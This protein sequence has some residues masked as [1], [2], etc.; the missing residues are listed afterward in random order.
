MYDLV[1]V[2]GGFAGL[3]AGVRAKELGLHAAI[4]EAGAEDEN[5]CN[6]RYSGGHLSIGMDD[7]SKDP[8][9][10]A[11]RINELT[12]HSFDAAFVAQ[13]AA[14]A[15]AMVDWL[16]S[17]NV[18]FLR[19]GADPSRQH[20]MAPPRRGQPGL[21]WKGRGPDQAVNGLARKFKALGGDIFFSAQAQELLCEEGVP[22]GITATCGGR[23]MELR[24]RNVVLAD[25][26]F[27]SNEEFLREFVTS[28][29]DR[30]FQ[31]N[32]RTAHGWALKAARKL[33]AQLVGM[34]KFYGHPLSRD[35]F[36]N[37]KL[38]PHPYLD[39]FTVC[40]IVVDASGQR[41]TDEGLGAVNLANTM[42][43]RE[44][45]M[46]AVVVF[47]SAIWNGPAADIT[48]APVPNPS[49]KLA[50][51][52]IHEAATLGELAAKAG[53]NAAALEAS[54]AA[55]NRAVL[56]GDPSAASPTRTLSRYK[57]YPLLKAP[58]YAMP[59]CAGITYT[60]G[61]PRVNID[62]QVL[63]EDGTCI[64][65]LYAVGSASGGLEGGPRS[66]YVGGIAKAVILGTSA[67]QH[68]ASAKR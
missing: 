26:G 54:V 3:S 58:F 2:G 62:A 7:V 16:R 41:F 64:P 13:Y 57:A 11:N 20:V 9:Y 60:M 17:H 19:I 38:W 49:L 21:D 18:K 15:G 52:T 61:G 44:D 30:L 68:I 8:A 28:R 6:S 32:A 33:G 27:Q 35:A 25:G 55:H 67:A 1:I 47:D 14:R 24:G 43:R 50:G 31:R 12:N 36:T 34:D 23:E 39:I 48:L 29:P 5:L 42:A 22:V 51:A 46:D 4:V 65:H 40:G 66:G 45:P 10:L 53:L 37:D 63:K 56:E 59:M